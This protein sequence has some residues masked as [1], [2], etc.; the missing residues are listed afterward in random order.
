MCIVHGT[1]LLAVQGFSDAVDTAC[2][3]CIYGVSATEDSCMFT[4][5]PG[6]RHTTAIVALPAAAAAVLLKLRSPFS[7]TLAHVS[8]FVT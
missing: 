5:N 8:E 3:T 1:V 2:Q 6:P 4:T 7:M